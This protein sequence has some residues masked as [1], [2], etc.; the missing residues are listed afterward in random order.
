M[1]HS[2]RAL[3]TTP[4]I[5]LIDLRAGGVS[6]TSAVGRNTQAAVVML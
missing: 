3:L 2:H 4:E 6:A 5:L 1:S